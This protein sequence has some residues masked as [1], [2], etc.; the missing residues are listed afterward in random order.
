M[1]KR[2]SSATPFESHKTG[3]IAQKSRNAV[4]KRGSSATPFLSPPQLKRL[5]TLYSQAARTSLEFGRSDDRS[6]RLAWASAN[7]KR[8]V[9]SFSELT[10]KEANDLIA[11]L[12]AA[13]G[14][15]QDDHARGTAGRR[16]SQSASTQLVT[17]ESLARVT[18]A[19]TRLGWTQQ[20]FDAWLH[21]QS[22]PLARTVNRVRIAPTNPKIVTQAHANR[23]WWA[24]KQMLKREGKWNA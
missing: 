16:N 9:T 23:V 4:N 22:S 1:M 6:A 5:Q 3:R 11:L 15:P 13:L 20:R 2:G 10:N 21:S 12:Q 18:D 17:A 8:P 14:M 24:L 7:L 19:I